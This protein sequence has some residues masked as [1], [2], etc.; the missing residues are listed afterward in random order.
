VHWSCT[1]TAHNLVG[2]KKYKIIIV[3]F[4]YSKNVLY[5]CIS[6]LKR[7]N[8]TQLVNSMVRGF[9]FTLGR[10]AAD[11]VLNSSSNY[12]SREGTFGTKN[13]WKAIGFWALGFFVVGQLHSTG[14]GVFWFFLGIPINLGILKVISYFKQKKI[15][16]R[17]REIYMNKIPSLMKEVKSLPLT[18]GI[19]DEIINDKTSFEDVELTYD[20]LERILSKYRPLMAKY[21][22]DMVNK[23]GMGYYWIGMTEENLIDMK[24]QPTNLETKI[25]KDVDIKVYVYGNKQ[26]G[27]I[28]TFENGKLTEFTDR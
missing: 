15:E 2:I 4:V 27:D 19:T 17:L 16:N 14:A 7:K 11:S 9:G 26:T 10:R 18:F 28:L 1:V 8:M 6:Q 21:D 5:I 12:S 20:S 23:I 13:Q 22:R 25:K 3:L 24:G